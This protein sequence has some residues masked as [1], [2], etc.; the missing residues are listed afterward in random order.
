VVGKNRE[1]CVI[2][3]YLFKLKRIF[4]KIAIRPSIVLN[5]VLLGSNM[6]IQ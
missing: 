1:E 5:V 4:Y 2:V 6:F 3:E